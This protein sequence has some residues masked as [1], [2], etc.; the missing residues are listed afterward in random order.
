MLEGKS[1]R[2]SQK[3]LDFYANR[4]A[5][6]EKI[7]GPVDVREISIHHLRQILAETSARSVV[8]SY[9]VVRRL[10]T[11]LLADEL[12]AKDPSAKLVAPK[13]PR[14][15]TQP[16]NP[17]AIS[18]IFQAAK[19]D[20]GWAGIRNAAII[21]TLVGT[22]IRSAELCGLREENV[23]LTDGLIRVL[24]KGNRERLVPIPSKLCL[25][26]K[27]Y[28]ILRETTRKYGKPCE[29][30]FRDRYGEPLSGNALLRMVRRAGAKAGLPKTWVHLMR[31]TFATAFMDNDGADIMTLKEIC[32]WKS[33]DMA[34]IYVKPTIRKMTQAQESFS[35]VNGL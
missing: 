10:F 3:T 25:I 27:K 14:K 28:A 24:G 34:L 26:L 9:R 5:L 32:G 11:F 4:I 7:V 22:G 12:I 35:P 19:S 20:H 17:K 15:V 29:F 18:A 13:I 8:H 2:L 33:L 21:A 16:L 6:F 1:R 31:H 30:F 23:N